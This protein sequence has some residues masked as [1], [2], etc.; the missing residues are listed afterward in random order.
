LPPFDVGSAESFDKS[1]IIIDYVI[2]S[3]DGGPDNKLPKYNT[4]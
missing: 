4:V 2:N 3:S 1:P